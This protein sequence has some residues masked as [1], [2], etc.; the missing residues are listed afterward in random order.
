M[1]ERTP[2][3]VGG[4]IKI[5]GQFQG[6]TW[7]MRHL[8]ALIFS[9]GQLARQPANTLM[10]AA[11][12]GI[13]LTLP[14]SLYVV[15]ENVKEL[16]GR[17]QGSAELSLYLRHG[18]PESHRQRLT[19][20]LN[21]LALVSRV[22]VIT[23][24]QALQEYQTLTGFDDLSA[25][26]GE[27]NP[28]PA[29]LVV[30]LGENHKTIENVATLSREL[31]E[32]PEVELVQSDL[33]WLVRLTAIIGLVERGIGIVAG[34]FGLGV[35]LIVGN[36][37]R[38]GIASRHDEIEVTRLIGGTD[39]FIRRPFLYSGL[40]Y[41]LLGAV[42]AWLLVAGSAQLLSGPV[43]ELAQLYVSEFR[44]VGPGGGT[45]V[46]LL[47]LGAGLGLVGSWLAVSRQLRLLE[48]G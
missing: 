10:S 47:V 31:S 7:L 14:T 38:M 35:L 22:V 41:G 29:V 33:K 24:T 34:L 2:R 4:T 11:V 9:F 30:F 23:P 21:A 16:T 25:A 20:E 8:H 37:I 19:E 15:L 17:W 18:L 12:I 13:A 42:V 5:R 36:T 45:V 6:A 27:D 28:L 44:L 40:W 1:T 26:L 48:A 32:R 43:R 46:V 3:N 39:A